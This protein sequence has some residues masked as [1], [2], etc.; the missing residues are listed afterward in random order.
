MADELD[1]VVEEA[2]AELAGEAPENPTTDGEN[3]MPQ[4]FESMLGEG[5]QSV[6]QTVINWRR[7]GQRGALRHGVTGAHIVIQEILD[8]ANQ[9]QA[10]LTIA[11]YAVAAALLGAGAWEL[12]VIELPEQTL[13]TED[14]ASEDPTSV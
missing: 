8:G 14:T 12:P 10:Y 6:Y 2:T 3:P 4:F 13:P 9:P 5:V 1:A 7:Q 11:A